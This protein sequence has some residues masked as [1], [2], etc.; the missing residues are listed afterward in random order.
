MFPTFKWFDNLQIGHVVQA[1]QKHILLS[2]GSGPPHHVL[3]GVCEVYVAVEEGNAERCGPCIC[4]S[5]DWGE[6]GGREGGRMERGREEGGG[7]EGGREDGERGGGGEGE[8][9]E[10]K[11]GGEKEGGREEERE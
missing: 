5:E 7:G 9:G 2:Y 11:M 6:E 4:I 1:L 10:G 8:V 3:G